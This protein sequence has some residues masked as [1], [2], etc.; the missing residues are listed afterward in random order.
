MAERTIGVTEALAE[1]CV[2]VCFEDLPEE[3]VEKTKLLLLDSI[4][5]ALGSYVVD[6]SRIAVELVKELGGNPQAT[7]IG[8]HLTS[9]ALAAFANGE[10]LN[11]LDYDAIGPLTAHV[12]P[13][14]IPSCLAIAERVHAS[15]KELIAALA[16]GHEIGGRVVNS[17]AQYKVLKDVPPYYEETQRFT[18][19]N[20][21]FGGVTGA[22]K[23]LG[24]DVTKTQ[25]AIGIAG[26]SA[27]VPAG[28]K[29]EFTGGPAIM[30][31][32]NAWTGHV[33][34]LATVAALLAEK[35]FTGDTTIMDG[36][37]GFWKIVGS[38]FFKAENLLQGLGKVWH[39]QQVEFKPY[40]TCRLN[41][42]GMEGINRIVKEHGIKPEE[43]EEIVVK[44][45][46][47]L[48][49][50]NRMTTEIESFADMQF[51]NVNIFA[52]SAFYGSS[53]SPAWLMPTS[54][55]DPRIKALSNKIKI[56]IHPRSGEFIAD[57]IKAGKL[58]SFWDTIIEITAK[59]GR[60]FTVE[61][62]R[63]KGTPANPMTEMELI[64]KFRTNASYSILPSNRSEDII[65][66]TKELEKVDDITKLTRLL[67]F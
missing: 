10:L 46:P 41:H 19:A 40:P 5:C 16:I 32:Y 62:A 52:A 51:S 35:G 26:A 17:L 61:I 67:T 1:S 24:L 25:N 43:I 58:P 59:G 18:F 54:F 64:E 65:Q 42:A 49:T 57:K 15:G 55:N 45:D 37:W 6:R 3:D 34:Q 33:A 27:P 31:K 12:C 11:A 50:P 30:V 13:Y 66:I 38:P 53:P 4:G 8:S 63:P 56:E 39:L 23:L 44:G 22:C 2:R 29:W 7:V 14:V 9:Y 28:L 20:A 36:E 48:L 47:N 21:I 60:E